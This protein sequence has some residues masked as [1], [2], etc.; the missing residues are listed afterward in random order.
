METIPR[1]GQTLHKAGHSDLIPILTMEIGFG[2]IT[3]KEIAITD[4]AILQEI[5]LG[6]LM[7]KEIISLN[8]KTSSHGNRETVPGQVL[9]PKLDQGQCK[10]QCHSIKQYW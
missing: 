2:E 3:G 9:G 7:N 5:I 10:V 8:S 6:G 1:I 4:Q